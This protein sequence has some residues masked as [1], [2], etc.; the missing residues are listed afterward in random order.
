M[1]ILHNKYEYIYIKLNFFRHL[2][3]KLNY[4]VI[5]IVYFFNGNIQWWY[6]TEWPSIDQ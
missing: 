6:F 4:F 5:L 2:D 1:S 3:A